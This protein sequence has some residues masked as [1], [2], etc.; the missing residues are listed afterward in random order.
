VSTAIRRSTSASE[1]RTKLAASQYAAASG[2]RTVRRPEAAKVITPKSRVYVAA[3]EPVRT[4]FPEVRILQL[5]KSSNETEFLQCARAGI[6]GYLRR[7]ASAKEVQ[8][9]VHVLQMGEVVCPGAL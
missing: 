7:N 2:F 6:N 3:E 4:T 1:N 8:E 9:A 5:V